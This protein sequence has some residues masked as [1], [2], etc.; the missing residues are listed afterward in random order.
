MGTRI[1]QNAKLET[2]TFSSSPVFEKMWLLIEQNLAFKL[3]LEDYFYMAVGSEYLHRGKGDGYM[4]LFFPHSHLMIS[5]LLQLLSNWSS[6]HT[7]PKRATRT[8]H[9]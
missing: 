2:N 9:R 6:L 4:Y 3:R 7:L 5:T 1:F 8:K